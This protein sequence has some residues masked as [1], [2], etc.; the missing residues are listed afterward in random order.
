[1]NRPSHW[2]IALFAIMGPALW[3]WGLTEGFAETSEPLPAGPQRARLSSSPSVEAPPP[4]AMLTGRVLDERGQPIDGAI[5][6]V[7]GGRSAA[8]TRA[9]GGFEVMVKLGDP[10]RRIEVTANNF[11]PA[12][13]R[14]AP[15]DLGN[16]VVQL[17]PAKPW[18]TQPQ[19][20]AP[21]KRAALVGEGFI[22]D[23]DRQ[24]L[25]GVV[26]T[27]LETG[28]SAL[29]DEIGRFRIPLG[30]PTV[31]LAAWHPTGRAAALDAVT[32]SQ[33]EGIVNL[34]VTSLADGV[35]VGGTVR[36]PDGGPAAA[37]A[38]VLRRQGLVRRALTDS[39]G[40]F[41]FSGLIAA[42]YVLEVLPTAGALGI[43]RPLRIDGSGRLPSEL[44]LIA[45]QPQRVHVLDAARAPRPKSFVVAVDADGRQAWAR[46][47]AEG[48]A[49]L[50]GLGAERVRVDEVRSPEH[51]RLTILDA[52][53]D[54]AT[55][56]VVAAP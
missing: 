32:P 17:L 49:T 16:F 51:T 50:R 46:A 24:P 34:G 55:I 52:K 4:E 1:M 21:G 3:V 56:T 8:F 18:E 42:D 44:R 9:S 47:D 13:E 25:T 29:T 15:S 10:Y 20:A 48:Y 37:A 40:V 41:E 11:T 14:C 27:A 30:A 19:V 45:E 39:S 54:A 2:I 31:S 36:L 12:V 23:H 6:R 35:Q 43:K 28:D 5:V 38:V 33:A 22:Y 53:A 26:V 7:I